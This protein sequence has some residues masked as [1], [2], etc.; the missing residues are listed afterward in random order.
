MGTAKAPPL[1]DRLSELADY[2]KIHGH[3]NV[4][5]AENAKM[6]I[7]SEPKGSNTGCNEKDRYD[8]PSVSRH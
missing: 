4:P 3:C 6:A 1:G 5:S 7:G 2:H 8:A